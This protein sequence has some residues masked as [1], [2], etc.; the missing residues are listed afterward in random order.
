[1]GVLIRRARIGDWFLISLLS[2]NMD[3][4]MFGEI[5]KKLTRK[6]T[7]DSRSRTQNGT[8][9]HKMAYGNEIDL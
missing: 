2:R 7:A 8:V 9:V 3:S 5:M 1:M 6:N 4:A